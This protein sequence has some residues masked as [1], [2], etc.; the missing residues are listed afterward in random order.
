MRYDNG[1]KQSECH[2][3]TYLT[4]PIG[5]KVRIFTIQYGKNTEEWLA[6]VVKVHQKRHNCN[7][8]ELQD[9]D[10]YELPRSF[11][12]Y[13]VPFFLIDDGP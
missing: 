5:T 7:I 11:I 9:E 6:Q 2:P 3:H 1:W 8:D 4:V 13:A 10:F 12:V